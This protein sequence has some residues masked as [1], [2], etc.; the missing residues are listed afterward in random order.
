MSFSTY[1]K[2][3]KIYECL[4]LLPDCLKEVVAMLLRVKADKVCTQDSIQNF[5]S[6]WT[7][8]EKFSRRP[9][10]MPK[11]TNARVWTSILDHTRQKG[12]MIILHQD[13]RVL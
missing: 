11:E 1:G 4:N 10:N 8:G 3:L 2:T 9:R 5:L 12:E 6:P 13:N 7:N